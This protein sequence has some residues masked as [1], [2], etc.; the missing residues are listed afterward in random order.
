MK[1]QIERA[2]KIVEFERQIEDF[3]RQIQILKGKDAEDQKKI[4][5]MQEVTREYGISSSDYFRFEA[6]SRDIPAKIF[7]DAGIS[8]LQRKK[9]DLTVKFLKF[10]VE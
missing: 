8:Y 4:Q 5:L 9:D 7:I 3:D 10:L 6:V 1:K 2:K